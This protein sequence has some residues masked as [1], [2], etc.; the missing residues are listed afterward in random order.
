M[1]CVGMLTYGFH[2]H[3]NFQNHYSRLHQNNDSLSVIQFKIKERLKPT[4]YNEKY[5]VN[6]VSINHQKTKGKLLL[7]VKKDDLTKVYDVDDVFL[8]YSKLNDIKPPLNPNQFDYKAYLKKQ[9]IYHQIYANQ[10]TLLKLKTRLATIFGYADQLRKRINS[11]LISYEFKSEEL[12][13][14]NALL[15]GQRQDMDREMYNDYAKAGAIHILAV[16]G[17]HVGIILMILNSLLKPVEYLKQG[18]LFKVILILIA[19]WSFAIIAGLSASVTRAV[20]MFSL[21]AIAMHLKRPTNIYN[22]LCI[23]L[24]LLLLIK[25]LFLFDVGFQMSYVAVFSIVSIQPILY[26]FWFPKLKLIDYFWKILTVTLA[27]Q[28]GVAPISLFYFHQFPGLFFI[29]NMAIIPFLGLI[30]GIGILVIV[31]SLFDILP[32]LINI[33][34]K[35]LISG[36]NSI[37]SWVSNQELFLI[38]EISLELTHALASYVLLFSLVYIIKKINFKS[39]RLL[40]VAIIITQCV[41]LYSN[42]KHSSE[43]FIVFHKNRKTLLTQ[44]TNTHLW[45]WHNLDSTIYRNNQLKDYRIANFIATTKFDSITNTYFIKSKTLL[46]VDSLGIYNTKLF[47]PNYILLRNSPK[48]N[49]KRLIDSVQPELIIADGSNYKSYVSRWKT[50]CLKE[51]LPFHSTYEKGAYIFE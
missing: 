12:T 17:L 16:S 33:F 19:L 8:T 38:K 6:L 42:Y 14:I 3:K 10:H 26:N 2:N 36:M 34:F 7:N 35:N 25:P 46:I 48:I 27:A 43:T 24:F 47:R 41:Y 32:Q 28:I 44:K 50:T 21:V 9:Y 1:I 15:L 20:T 31:L 13:V 37:V 29:S 23:S 22:T 39:V 51:K 30:L 18:K 45:V 4:L 49:L 5:V 40:L 11:K